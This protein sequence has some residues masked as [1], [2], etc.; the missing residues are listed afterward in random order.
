MFLLVK[1][2]VQ[3]Q[4]STRIVNQQPLLVPNAVLHHQ[5][6]MYCT[7]YTHTN[8]T[9]NAWQ[10][11]GTRVTSLPSKLYYEICN[12]IDAG[13]HGKNW[14]DLAGWFDFT[15]DQV[16]LF[17]R[18]KHP[19]DA[20]I[21]SWSTEAANDIETFIGILDKNKM[22]YLVDKIEKERALIV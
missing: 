10:S 9:N 11:D 17:E 2:P 12:K 15:A 7:N 13:A 4:Q 8:G 16:Q 18:E 19:T 20:I 5:P 1:S 3:E 21:R 14:R 6:S 22:T